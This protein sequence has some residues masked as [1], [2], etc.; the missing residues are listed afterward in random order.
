MPMLQAFWDLLPNH[1]VSELPDKTCLHVFKDDIQPLWED[2]KNLCGGHFKITAKTQ[3]H[4]ESMWLDVVMNLLGEQFPHRELVVCCCAVPRTRSAPL[5]GAA[6]AER[7]RPLPCA[8][9]RPALCHCFVHWLPRRKRYID[10]N[11]H[12]CWV[13]SP[14][15]RTPG[16][17]NPPPPPPSIWGELG[18]QE[19][20]DSYDTDSN[21]SG[22]SHISEELNEVNSENWPKRCRYS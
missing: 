6:S 5:G 20:P 9:C 12:Q 8:A 11:R 1:S 21:C 18:L 2:P 4:S 3:P 13:S 16:S 14:Q 10:T 17:G 19:M 22:G 15:H 7:C